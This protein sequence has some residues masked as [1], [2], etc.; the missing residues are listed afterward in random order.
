MP[1]DKEEILFEAPLK[2]SLEEGPGEGAVSGDATLKLT[3]VGMFVR[4]RRGEPLCLSYH[5]VLEYSAKDHA[6]SLALSSAERLKLTDIGYGYDDLIRIF[7][8]FRNEML[9]RDLLMKESTIKKDVKADLSGNG[10][11]GQVIEAKN[12]A[13]RICSTALVLLFGDRDPVRIPFC[14]ILETN[15]G[16]FKLEIKT[17]LGE[18]YVLSG[19]GYEFGPFAKALSDRMGELALMVQ[20][21]LREIVPGADPKILRKA[22]GLMREG[23]A[24][25]KSDLDAISPDIWRQ[26]E[27]KMA[28]TELK[29]EYEFLR[30]K[31]QDTRMGIGLKRDSSGEYLWFL[32][33][34]YSDDPR[35]PGNL[36]AMESVTEKE[37]GKATYFY[38][39]VSRKD[40]RKSLKLEELHK[41]ADNAIRNINRCMLAINFRRE[42]IYLPP[43]KLAEPQYQKYE[44]AIAGVPGL[45]MLRELYV[46]RVIHSSD[47]QWKEDVAELLKFNSEAEDGSRWCQKDKA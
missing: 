29:E 18:K 25:K 14:D 36:I 3:P 5:D 33:P 15:E 1:E 19:M 23:K 42:P 39:I 43:E 16:D 44:Y 27:R 6:I 4:P 31:A 37:T 41:E 24:A 28:L 13:L 34:I 20:T 46:G 12:V 9:L 40:Y 7:T 35:V 10:A 32:A 2:Y 45:R 8:G 26:L 30:S 47:G 21:T 38:R 17:E 22:A 11:D